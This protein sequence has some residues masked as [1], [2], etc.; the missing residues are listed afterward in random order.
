MKKGQVETV[1]LVIIVILLLLIGLV[2]LIFSS[3]NKVDSSEDL[4][5]TMKANNLVNSIL[6]VD[7]GNSNFEQKVID[8]C[9]GVDEL[10]C[11]DMEDVISSGMALIDEKMTFSVICIGGELKSFG[12]CEFGLNSVRLKLP[13]EDIF[14]ATICRK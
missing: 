8:C 3:R 13:S 9:A 14:Y 5:L 6:H 1:G 2:V 10:S 12:D 4:F 7:V 11:R